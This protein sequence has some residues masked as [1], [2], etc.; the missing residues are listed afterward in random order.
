MSIWGDIAGAGVGLY[1]YNE[2]MQQMDQTRS[3]VND[4]IGGLQSGVQDMTGFT[5]WGVTSNLGNIGA[6]E[7]GLDYSL[8]PTQQGYADQQGQGAATLFERALQDPTARQSALYGQMQSAR[9]P[10]MERA[11]SDL[12]QNIWGR[13]TGGMQTANYG[14]NPEQYA[15]GKALA[16]SQASD[17]LRANQMANAEQLQ[18][19]QIG[20][21]MFGNQYTPQAQLAQLAQAGLNN[22]QLANDM[23]RERASLW[24]QLGLGGLSSN[25]NY[26][27]IK[28]NAFGDMIQAG[29]GLAQGAGNWLG[30]NAGS[31]WDSIG[32]LFGG[33]N[34]VLAAHSTQDWTTGNI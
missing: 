17:M 7:G 29:T 10:E 9:Q 12:Q 8:S 14:G 20:Q 6:T 24:T 3:D 31:I 30:N 5:P 13:G 16:D 27:N 15:F 32:G 34:G 22:Q 21:Q 33:G 4:T 1:G 19:A 28:G 18:Q 23:A 11:Y 2:L 25:V 26:D